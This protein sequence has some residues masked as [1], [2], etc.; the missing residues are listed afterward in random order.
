VNDVQNW[1]ISQ[2]LYA[3]LDTAKNL[4]MV[5]FRLAQ[6]LSQEQASLQAGVSKTVWMDLE[7]KKLIPSET[8]A[9]KI[10]VLIGKPVFRLFPHRR[11]DTIKL[12]PLRNMSKLA[13]IRCALGIGQVDLAKRAAVPIRV[14][15][16]I[17]REWA[18]IQDIPK[19]YLIHVQTLADYLGE[20]VV[21]IVGSVVG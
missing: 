10:A 4:D 18:A 20:D 16:R 3:Q 21:D 17:E 8:Q 12:L 6:N 19:D 14:L 5:N 2:K 15:Q 11:H 7:N 13:F 1:K 9:T